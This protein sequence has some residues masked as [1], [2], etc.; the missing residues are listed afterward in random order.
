MNTRAVSVGIVG[1]GHVMRGA[2]T[3]QL[4]GLIGRGLVGRVLLCDVNPQAARKA[5]EQ[6]PGSPEGIGPM[7]DHERCRVTGSHGE[8]VLTPWGSPQLEIQTSIGDRPQRSSIDFVG[9]NRYDNCLRNTLLTFRDV[10]RSEAR[11][12]CTAEDGLHALK[13]MVAAYGSSLTGRRVEF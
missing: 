7:A 10:V 12:R 8:L 6:L 3:N 9:R 1:C 4:R 13:M 5:A 2:Y 11:N